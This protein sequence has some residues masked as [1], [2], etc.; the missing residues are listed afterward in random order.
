MT[1]KLMPASLGLFHMS[2]LELLPAVRACC[3]S[4]PAAAGM[5]FDTNQIDSLSAA[6]HKREGDEYTT[7]KTP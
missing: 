2:E 3:S 5:P 1:C 7:R 6:L 4:V